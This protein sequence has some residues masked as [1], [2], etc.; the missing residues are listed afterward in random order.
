MT[1][2][3]PELIQ[4]DMV[5]QKQNIRY[6]EDG[7]FDAHTS[8]Q[9]QLQHQHELWMENFQAENQERIKLFDRSIESER[10]LDF[11]RTFLGYLKGYAALF[12]VPLVIDV[13]HNESATLK[14]GVA[15]GIAGM[16]IG[17]ISLARHKITQK[18]QQHRSN[19]DASLDQL[20]DS[21][22]TFNNSY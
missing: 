4:P 18:I 13:V 10:R 17:G 8:V 3:E 1:T 16:T 19:R 12:T 5:I 20:L 22:P 2:A 14:D 11:Y 21:R 6:F 7:S 15:I 9:A